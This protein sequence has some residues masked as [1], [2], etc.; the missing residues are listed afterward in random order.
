MKIGLLQVGLFPGRDSTL[1]VD[2]DVRL[3]LE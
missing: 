3:A 2:W 1:R